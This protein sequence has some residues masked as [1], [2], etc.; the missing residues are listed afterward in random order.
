[1]K[2]YEVTVNLD[3]CEFARRCQDIAEAYAAMKAISTLPQAKGLDLERIMETLVDAKC[4]LWDLDIVTPVYH[5][6]KIDYGE[7]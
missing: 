1:M 7:V 4:N 6:R 2:Y 3:G 5:L